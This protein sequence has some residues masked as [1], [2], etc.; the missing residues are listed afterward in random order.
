MKLEVGKKVRVIKHIPS[1]NGMLYGGSIVKIDDITEKN[2]V[3]GNIRVVDAL[4]G[5]WWVEQDQI[6]DVVK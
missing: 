4:G 5:I 1:I 6:T 3:R 2:P